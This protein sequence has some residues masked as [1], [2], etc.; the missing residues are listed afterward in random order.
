MLNTPIDGGPGVYL[1]AVPVPAIGP[2]QP[3]TFYLLAL[4][5]AVAT[6]LIA[7]AVYASRFGLGLFA[8]HDD[9]EAAEVMGVPTYRFK[10]AA[11]GLSC[12]LAG[13]AGGIHAM[14][15]SYVTAGE[16]FSITVP[17]TV[18]LMSVLG[19]TR[20]WA[21]PAVGA[22]IITGLLYAFTAGDHAV[23]G[24]ARS[25]PYWW[26][27][28]CSCPGILALFGRFGRGRVATSG[29]RRGN[30]RSAQRPASR[31]VSQR[32]RPIQQ[33]PPAGQAQ[34]QALGACCCKRTALPSRSRD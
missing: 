11:F 3:A 9:E 8:I 2:T 22:T 1:N 15:I 31:E 32:H 12:A 5:A 6:L 16:V 21:G 23:L 26:P 7:W 4:M 28:S 27:P 34:R 10:L 25:A 14:F 19:G 18:V 20:H 33:R 29:G 24:K 17:L 13:I 30:S